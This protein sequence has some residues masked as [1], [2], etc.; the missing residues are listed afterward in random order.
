M[1]LSHWA[2]GGNRKYPHTFA[3]KKLS[4]KIGLEKR[5]HAKS[6]TTGWQVATG[7]M[8]V[9]VFNLVQR[10]A[11]PV[12][13]WTKSLLLAAVTKAAKNPAAVT[14]AAAE[15]CSSRL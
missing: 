5:L 12:E 8:D 1:L 15:S 2:P 7:N 9:E 10:K 14:Y 13:H 3:R 11:V 6:S 4:R